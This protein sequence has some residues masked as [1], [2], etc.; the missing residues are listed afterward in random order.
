MDVKRRR[1]SF[2]KLQH[3]FFG[4]TLA[5]A[6]IAKQVQASVGINVALDVLQE[7]FGEGVAMHAK[8]KYIKNR[9]LAIEVAHP[10]IAEE[11][12]QQEEAIISEIN[13]RLGRHEVVAMQFLLDKGTGAHIYE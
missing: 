2:Q 13:K 12:T 6:G 5:R 4:S 1:K 7:R 8:P 3:T 9:T 10:A 11:I